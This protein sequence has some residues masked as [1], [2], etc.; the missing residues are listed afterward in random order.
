MAALRRIASVAVLSAAAV[1]GSLVLAGTAQAADVTPAGA[2]I[3]T[4][5]VTPAGAV[6]S[7]QGVTPDGSVIAT[8]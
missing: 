5:G 3:S 8:H 6:I 4:Q 2:V 1:S 7:T